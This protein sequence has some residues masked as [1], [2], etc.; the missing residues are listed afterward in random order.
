MARSNTSRFKTMIHVILAVFATGATLAGCGGGGAERS[1]LQ[2]FFRASQV[3]DRATAGN[4][5]MVAYDSREQGVVSGVSVQNVTE[6]TRR[7]LRTRDLAQALAQAQTDEQEHAVQMREYQDENLEAIARVIAAERGG[8]DVASADE[9]VQQEW[10]RWREESAGHSSAVSESEVA[11]ADESQIAERSTFS[12]ST[13]IDVSGFDGELVSKDVTITANV[14]LDGNSEE[15]TM[16]ITLQMV[17]LGSGEDM[18][19]GRWIISAIQ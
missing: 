10:V 2:S 16:V 4:I 11:L 18:I 5:S 15:R 8:E 7:P 13:P 3:D 19:E 1:L 17:E 9:E 12:P 14:E 6:E